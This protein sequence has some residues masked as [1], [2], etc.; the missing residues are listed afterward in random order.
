MGW[1]IDDLVDDDYEEVKSFEEWESCVP[2]WFSVPSNF[3]SSRR[4]LVPTWG[5]DE[6]DLFS[7]D[8]AREL[9]F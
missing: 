1:L 7:K 5:G 3:G 9:E 2:S 8:D 4:M 6:V